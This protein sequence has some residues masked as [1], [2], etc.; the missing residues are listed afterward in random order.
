MNT[1]MNTLVTHA[2]HSQRGTVLITA[3]I[4]MVVLTLV[5]VVSM[6]STTLD[7]KMTTN[8]ML[9]SRAFE[10]SETGR[11]P[12]MPILDAHVFNRAWEPAWPASVGGNVPASADFT[13][14]DGFEVCPCDTAGDPRDLWA[15][16]NVDLGEPN[17]YDTDNEDL[18]YRLDGNG[19]TDFD[20]AE[21][22]AAD[23][24]ITRL[25]VVPAS[26]GAIAQVSGYEGFGKAAAAGGGFLYFD[27]QARGASAGNARATTG[28]EVR[29]VIRN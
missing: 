28:S 3:L 20:D 12:L 21:D 15:T 13:V 22:V 1:Q 19:D 10:N 29:V 26:G 25:S 24:F 4:F 5:A 7:L 11:D 6:R 16:N 9:K 14:P 23:L 18:R 17:F 8:T 2:P 27:A